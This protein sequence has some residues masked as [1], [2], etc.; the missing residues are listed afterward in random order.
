M[1]QM[2]QRLK[3]SSDNRSVR[4]SAVGF[5][6]H[7]VKCVMKDRA[8]WSDEIDAVLSSEVKKVTVHIAQPDKVIYAQTFV[9]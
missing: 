9:F 7:Y 2:V 1:S 3:D 6:E 8:L 5:Y 4:I